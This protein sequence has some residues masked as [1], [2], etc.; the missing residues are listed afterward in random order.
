MKQTLVN[1]ALSGVYFKANSGIEI[2]EK[3]EGRS[4]Q[5]LK[6]FAI[7]DQRNK[8]GWRAIWE[9]IKKNI[10]TFKDKPGI[11]FTKCNEDG[12]DLDHTEAQTEELSLKVQEPFRVSTIIGNT[13]D[14]ENHTAFFIHKVNDSNF[15]EKIK[16]GKIKFV[17]PSIWPKSGGYEIVGQTE[18]GQPMIDVWDWGGLHDAFVN[19]PAFGD[20]AKITATCE[21]YNCPVKL[22]TASEKKINLVADAVQDCVTR[23]VKDYGQSP[24]EQ[25]LAIFYSEC[26]KN[27]SGIVDQADLPHL[28]EIPLLIKHNKKRR[29]F[30]VNQ[31]VLQAVQ[32]LLDKGKSVD[33]ST[34]F[35]IVRKIDRENNSFKSCTCSKDHTMD[36]NEEKD[37]R[38][39]LK[40]M[41]E[42]KKDL[43]SKLNAQN[44]DEE[45]EKQ[46][47]ARVARLVAIFNA[48]EHDED[49]EKVA[50]AI[51]AMDDEDE[52]HAMDEAEKEIKS[53]S[54]SG[55][56]DDKKEEEQ[57]A[58][59]A[60]LESTIA[61]PL[62]AKMVKAR[63][64]KGVNE[65]DIKKFTK[66]LEGKSLQAIEEKYNDEKIFIESELSAVEE[67]LTEQ[68]H[69]SFNAT[70]TKALSGKSLEEIFEEVIA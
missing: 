48:M 28:Q 42:E 66:S 46:A 52:K 69:F 17:S 30:S 60:N 41:E 29:F 24:D 59:I 8:N 20:D 12:C 61:E 57:N 70:D 39:K 64:S 47:K 32:K 62:V 37:L 13:L 44:N 38:S 43:E 4:G 9:G 58:K 45:K 35:N 36:E 5:F 33:D 6:T 19:K 22:L 18:D 16:K 31:N 49:K 7:N 15:F 3:Y 21:G 27:L 55:Q 23:K 1:V 25:K 63:E 56:N 53:K 68:K 34:L 2:L 51:R 11:E 14:E 10:D 40:A 50:K 54:K 67:Q 26:R 65:D